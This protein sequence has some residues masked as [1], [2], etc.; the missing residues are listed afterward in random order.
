[1]LKQRF[2]A[3]VAEGVERSSSNQQ[4]GGSNPDFPICMPISN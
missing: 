3:A 2:N 1:M 4:V